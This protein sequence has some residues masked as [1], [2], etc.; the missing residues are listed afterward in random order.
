MRIRRKCVIK[1]IN[2]DVGQLAQIIGDKIIEDSS[3]IN[4]REIDGCYGDFLHKR[5]YV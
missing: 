3:S 4:K 2:K 1:A 5:I